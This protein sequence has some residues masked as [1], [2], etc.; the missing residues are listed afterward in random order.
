M[1]R[2]DKIRLLQDLRAGKVMTG[3]LRDRETEI[4]VTCAGTSYLVDGK[5]VIRK[6]YLKT[7]TSNKL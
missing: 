5:E 3:D 1:Q 6:A 7:G 4:A 2:N